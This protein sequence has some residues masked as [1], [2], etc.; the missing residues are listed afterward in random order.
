MGNGITKNPCFSGDPYAAAVASDPLPDDSQGHSFTYVPSGA[1]FE[2]PPT[3]AATSS[4][5]SS[6]FS[7]SGAAIS[8]NPATS[9]SMP[10]FQVLNEMTWPQS[11]ACTFES[12]RS[13]AAVPLQAAP[14]RLSMSGPV[15]S[16]SGRFSETSGSASTISGPPSDSP[17]MS[18]PLDLAVGLQPSVSQLIAER[19]AARSRLRDERSLLRFFVGTASKLRLGSRRYR[20]RPQEPA[21]PIKVSFSDGDYRSPPN[22]NVEWAQGMAG[23]DRF[24]VAVSEEHGWVFVGIYDGFNGPDATDYL[25]ANLYGVVHNELKGVLWDDIQAGDDARCGQQEAAAGNA[26]RLCLAEADGD[27]SEAKRRRTEVPVPGNNATPVHRDVLRALARALKKTE[28]AFFA[29][30][31]ERAAESPELG[32]VGSCVLV[33]VMKGTDVYVMNVGDSRAVLA[34]RPEP[35]LKNVL[36]KASQ[37]LQQFKAEIMRELEAH[38]MDGL[39]AVQLTAEHST[40]V[41]EEVMRIKGQHLNDRNAIV[42]GRVKGKINVTR[43]F[44]VA[45]LKQPK[46]NSRL[47]E[48]FRINYVGTDP[49]VTCAPSLCH[50]RIVSSQDK[51]LVLSSDGLYQYFT[52]KEVVDQVEAFTAAEP[53]GDPA[54]HLVGELVHRAA[55]KAGMETRQ[56]LEIPRGARRHYHDDVSIIVI[57]FEGHIWRSSV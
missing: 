7:L 42:N 48:A 26:E 54:Q 39:Q 10:S 52:N 44:G 45:Y 24:H 1:A 22:G 56:L 27:S 43:A 36:G 15:Q 5:E 30:A 16:T 6:F 53:D 21:E 23:E 12:S 47:L 28:D 11:T 37:D 25:F 9:A 35:D 3:A 13:F 33:M 29:A 34:R 4:A 41:H 17:F 57:S 38:D 20:R 46:W 19:R 2:Q 40:A 14:P 8:A 32:L 49:Y 51:F 50:H 18:G 31:E 55:R